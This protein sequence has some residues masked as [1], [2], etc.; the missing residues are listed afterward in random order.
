MESHDLLRPER[1]EKTWQ[2]SD[3][4]EI[5]SLECFDSLRHKVTLK[6][7]ETA[8]IYVT[9]IGILTLVE[10]SR[11]QDQIYIYI[12]VSFLIEI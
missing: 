10:F 6:K 9:M 5:E 11:A 12:F 1:T 7:R 3:Y 4:K 8:R 2:F